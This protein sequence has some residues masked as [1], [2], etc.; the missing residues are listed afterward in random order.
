MKSIYFDNAATTMVRDEVADVMLRVMRENYGNPS[1][2]HHLGRQA[3]A[4]LEVARENVAGAFGAQP[5]DV[6]FT[7]GGTE[8][9]NWAVL[10]ASE[11]RARAGKHIL[12]SAIEHDAVM[13]PLKK[14]GN[15]GWDV[16]Y[17]APD[18]AGR[19][20]A[21]AFAAALRED[22]VFATVMLVNNETGAINPV[23]EYSREIKRRGLR[24]VLHTDA[25]QGFCKIPLNVKTLGADIVSVSAHK[26]HGPKGVGALYVKEGVKLSPL[27]FGGSQ[28]KGKR[29]GTEALP[30][31][32]GF[33]EAARLGRLEFHDTSEAVRKVRD[34]AITLLSEQLPEAVIIGAGDSPFL[35]NLSLPGYKSEVLMSFL[36]SE[37]ICVSKSSACKKGA[38][39]R[40]LEAMCLK[41]EVID[42]A[43]RVSFSRFNTV[44]ESECFVS[45]LK[46]ASEKL[47]KNK[48]K[49]S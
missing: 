31:I 6:Y 21:D 32:A 1:S 43:L 18:G 19:V 36:D 20:T 13:E 34:H 49:N 42:G 28:E 35:L 38:R 39:S 3:A 37:G 14:L 27:I 45:T 24:T 9:D 22:T 23:S 11:T 10:N 17:L 44:E 25:V 2:I 47:I 15:M 30:A 33:G 41:N 8:S 46:C 16:T 12:A 26:I 40:V 48:S 7:S 4:E 5:R 29:P